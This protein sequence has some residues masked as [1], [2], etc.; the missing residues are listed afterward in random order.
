MQD[1]YHV[2]AF[3]LTKIELDSLRNNVDGYALDT[4][5]NGSSL[6]YALSNMIKNNLQRILSWKD[7]GKYD[8]SLLFKK[9]LQIAVSPDNKLYAFSF[10]QKTGGSYHSNYSFVFYNPI[11]GISQPYLDVDSSIFNGDGYYAIDTIHTKQGIKYLLSGSVVGCNTCMGDYIDLVHYE[12][13]TFVSDFG[14]SVSTRSS[15]SQDDGDTP[16]IGY[17]YKTHRINID[18][19]TSDLTPYCNCGANPNDLNVDYNNN[20]N[21]SEIKCVYGFNGD[22]FVL[23]KANTRPIKPS[24]R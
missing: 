18:Y 6:T 8:L 21:E 19:L 1:Q 7:I 16:V 17:D 15:G 14:Y 20:G 12:K 10:D 22:T 5:M 11:N 4:V 2:K 13:A 9:Y 24:K 23:K 3:K